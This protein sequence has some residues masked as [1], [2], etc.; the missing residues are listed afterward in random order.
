MTSLKGLNF[1]EFDK[2]WM[3][4]GKEICQKVYN[5]PRVKEIKESLVKNGFLTLEEK[6]EFINISDRIKY[7]VIYARYGTEDSEGYKAFSEAWKNWFQKKGVE[8]SRNRGQRNSVEHILFGSTPDP[9]QFL[10]HFEQEVLN[11]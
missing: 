5:N 4:L 9:V 7:E 2:L 8:S 3:E 6:S 11:K 10:N 1:E